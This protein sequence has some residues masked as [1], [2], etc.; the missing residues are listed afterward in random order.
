MVNSDFILRLEDFH[1]A[2]TLLS[3]MNGAEALDKANHVFEGAIVH[4]DCEAAMGAILV[5][6]HVNG[7]SDLTCLYINQGRAAGQPI[8]WFTVNGTIGITDLVLALA[9][10][11]SFILAK[12]DAEVSL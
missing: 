9:R 4:V 10:A 8:P 1:E 12:Q 7:S 3:N 6:L 5:L 11:Q 2:L